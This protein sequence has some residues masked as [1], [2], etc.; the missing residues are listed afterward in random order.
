MRYYPIYLDLK[1]RDV[2]VVGGG[3]VA[4]GKALQL[5]EAGARVTVVSPELTETL[6]EAAGRNE[7]VY[8]N[9]S[10]TEENLNGMFLVISATNDRKTNERVAH[11]AA[12]RGLLCNVVD[13]PDLCNF[14]TPALVTRG[15]LQI[16]VSTGGASP[17]LTQR[18]KREVA[19]LI[20]DEY[21]TLLELAAEMRAEAKSRI[22][23]FERRKD[24]LRAFVES[25]AIDLIRAGRIDDA[26]ALARRF[27]QDA[28]KE[29]K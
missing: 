8:L 15:K 25:G 7:V 18:V 17:T 20:G 14:I 11:A 22:A 3:A 21:G 24:A 1:G 4:E 16:S 9:G 10:F 6:R 28:E 19:A 13:Q 5:V 27:L 23:D 29:G 26:R 12:E 2:L